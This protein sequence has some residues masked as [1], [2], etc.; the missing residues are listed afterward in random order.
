MD[1]AAVLAAR[2]SGANSGCN[3]SNSND[4]KPRQGIHARPT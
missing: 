4:S 2:G 1:H 3:H